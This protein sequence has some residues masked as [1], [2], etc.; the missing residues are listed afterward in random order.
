MKLQST[1]SVGL[2][3]IAT[4]VRGFGIVFATTGNIAVF[5]RMEISFYTK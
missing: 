5:I 3:W 1:G 4:V 2:G